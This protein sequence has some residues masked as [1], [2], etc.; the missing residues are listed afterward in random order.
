MQL[1]KDLATYY[2]YNDY[3][4]EA[5]LSLFSPGEA[6]ELME[7]N[8]VCVCVCVWYVLP[9]AVFYV[10]KVPTTRHI[11]CSGKPSYLEERRLRRA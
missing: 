8:E 6:V 11:Q 2:G 7:A 3:M 1:R 10:A 5:L 9:C 4:L